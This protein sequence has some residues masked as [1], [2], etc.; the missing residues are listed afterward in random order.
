MN[1]RYHKRKLFCLWN[2]KDSYCISSLV[3]ALVSAICI[4]YLL[5]EFYP[6]LRSK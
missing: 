1:S 2:C 5:T 3:S 6:Q 4:S